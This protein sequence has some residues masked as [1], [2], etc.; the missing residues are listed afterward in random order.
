MVRSYMVYIVDGTDGT[1]VAEMAIHMNA[2][3]YL[4]AWVIRDEKDS[5]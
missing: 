3:F 5:I 4:T 1:D 2:L